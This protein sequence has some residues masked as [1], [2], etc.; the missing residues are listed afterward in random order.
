MGGSHPIRGTRSWK[1]RRV[2]AAHH[3]FCAPSLLQEYHGCISANDVLK[4]LIIGE[5]AARSLL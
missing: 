5:R 3:P 1:C 2:A 4:N